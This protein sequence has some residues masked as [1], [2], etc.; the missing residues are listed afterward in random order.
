MV[1]IYDYDDLYSFYERIHEH[2]PIITVQEYIEGKDTNLV[3]FGSYFNPKTSVMSYFT[4]RKL[5][6]YP[7]NSGTGIVVE[8]KIIPEIIKPSIALLRQLN[9]SGISEIT[10]W[11]VFY[12]TTLE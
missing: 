12:S 1:K 11:Q 2:D 10:G 7:A 4:A 3:I 8:N 6:Q 9:Y 5:I